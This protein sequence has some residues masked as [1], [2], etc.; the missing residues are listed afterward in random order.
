[1]SHYQE[2]LHRSS[3]L[4]A[5]TVVSFWLT[6][7]QLVAQTQETAFGAYRSVATPG[8][9]ERFLLTHGKGTLKTLFLWNNG[10]NRLAS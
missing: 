6:T 8:Q 9:F 3:H 4:F 10:G 7:Y 2:S 1:M 5:A